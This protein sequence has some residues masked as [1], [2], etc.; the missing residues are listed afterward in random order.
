MLLDMTAGVDNHEK[1]QMTTACISDKAKKTIKKLHSRNFR[2]RKK[3]S[4]TAQNSKISRLTI[5]N[6]LKQY[7]S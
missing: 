2:L 6:S 5:I 3:G 1:P 7:L 4:E